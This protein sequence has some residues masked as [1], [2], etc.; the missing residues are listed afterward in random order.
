MFRVSTKKLGSVG[1]QETIYTH[2]HLET[3]YF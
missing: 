2:K 1:Q 3:K